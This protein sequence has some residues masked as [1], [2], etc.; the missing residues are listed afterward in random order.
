MSTFTSPTVAAGRAYRNAWR[1]LWLFVVSF[2]V[3]FAFFAVIW[4]VFGYTVIWGTGYPAGAAVPTGW[5]ALAIWLLLTV[6]Y[7]SPE[8][9]VVR[10][11]RQAMR[12]GYTHWLAPV[13][14]GGA[15]AALMPLLNVGLLLG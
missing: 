3:S 2:V 4:S 14:V 1:S 5:T 12:S 13:V 9:L 6:V 10:Y 15:V 7:A 8:V 11:A